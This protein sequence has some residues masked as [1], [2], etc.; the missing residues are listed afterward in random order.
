MKVIFNSRL[1]STKDF[2]LN[3]NNRSFCYGDGLFETIVTGPER[4]NLTHR[5]ITRLKRGCEI[6]GFDFPEM[7][8]EKR[9]SEFISML[10][11]ENDLTGITRSRLILWRNEG[12]LYSP[13]NNSA[14]FLIQSIP[15]N[16]PVFL[17]KDL[18]GFSSD[19]HTNFSPIS[20]AKTTNA[21]TYVLAGKQMVERGWNDIL[22]C[23]SQ[24]N[25]A[26]T[27]IANVFWSAGD[28]IFTPS[29]ETGCIEGV[30]RSEIIS[31]FKEH[32]S[33]INEVKSRKEALIEADSVFT[34][35]AS[36]IC[37]FG[38]VEGIGKSFKNPELVLAPY[39]KRLQQ[40]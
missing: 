40:P 37:Y 30:M 12:G 19:Y 3:L 24:G 15:Q 36:G 25:I 16:S 13:S 28:E 39:L 32:G 8:E 9:L 33:T 4:I 11:I 2:S 38:N 7:L 35:N 18:A 22:L 21:L 31:F 34:T 5:H 17:R 23:D 6:I 29:L 14:S 27:H 10:R 1:Q 26:E 20:F